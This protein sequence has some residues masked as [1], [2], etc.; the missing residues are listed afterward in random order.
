MDIK[1]TT[2]CKKSYTFFSVILLSVLLTISAILIDFKTLKAS[3][4]SSISSA[5]KETA[6]KRIGYISKV[7]ESNKKSF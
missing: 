7:Y 5:S 4:V 6:Q 1:I 3:T 2:M